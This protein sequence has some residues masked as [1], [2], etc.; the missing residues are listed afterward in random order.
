MDLL[1]Y[2]LW[3]NPAG[4]HYTDTRVQIILGLC[5]ALVLLSF[6]I[7]FWRR[8]IKNPITKSLSRSWS[9][10]SLWFGLLGIVFVVSRTEMIQFLAM[11]LLWVL[12]LLCAIFYIGFQFIQFRRR[13]YTVM[14]RMQVTDERDRYLPRGG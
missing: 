7:S 11:R 4:W 3:P 6:V 8:S 12:W 14:Q 10:A 13:H 1:S 2:W 9:S 5:I